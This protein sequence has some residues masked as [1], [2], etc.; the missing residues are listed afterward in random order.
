MR[1]P[2]PRPSGR[3]SDSPLRAELRALYA[4]TDELVQGWSCVCSGSDPVVPRESRCCHFAVTGREPYPTAVELEE[5]RHAAARLGMGARS[6]KLPVV[7][8]SGRGECPMLAEDQRCRIYD[9]RPFGCRTF[10]C[11]GATSDATKKAG[12]RA[13]LPR[14]EIQAVSRRIADLSARFAPRDPGPRPLVRALLTGR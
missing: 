2:R 10:F 1:E 8:A 9:S 6:R 14:D 7:S 3:W 11:D 4:R 5:V 12:G 13:R